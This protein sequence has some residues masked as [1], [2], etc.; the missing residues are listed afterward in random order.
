MIENGFITGREVGGPITDLVLGILE[1]ANEFEDDVV[2]TYYSKTEDG[3]N[4]KSTT[5]IIRNHS[6]QIIGFMCINID[7]S[8]PFQEVMKAFLPETTSL[9]PGGN[10]TI[11]SYFPDIDSLVSKTIEKTITG[12][13]NR[14]EISPTDKN[15]VIVRE[16]YKGGMFNIKGIVDVVAKQ[17]GISRYTVYN[18]LRDAKTVSERKIE[19]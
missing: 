16:L 9:S 6:Q 17:M 7:L 8:A 18:Y 15:K 1:K 19:D 4:L 10:N 14:R 12:I 2:G 3:R 5:M 13:S 11:E